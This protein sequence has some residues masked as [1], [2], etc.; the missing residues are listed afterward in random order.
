MKRRSWIYVTTDPVNHSGFVAGYGARELIA[1]AGGRPLWSRSRRAWA[2]SEAT[3]IDV[4]A[5][6]EHQGYAVRY[7]RLERDPG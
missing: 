1:A 6:A 2:T 5:A 3:A 4:L 7:E